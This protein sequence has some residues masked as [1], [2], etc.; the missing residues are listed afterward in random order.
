MEST[1]PIIEAFM[2]AVHFLEMVVK[3]GKK[4]YLAEKESCPSGMALV[5]TLYNL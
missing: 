4:P 1:R 5:F 2:H 3:Y